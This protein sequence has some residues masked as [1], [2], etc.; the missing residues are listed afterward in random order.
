M[1]A[2][3]D[4]INSLRSLRAT[5]SMARV[6]KLLGPVAFLTGAQEAGQAASDLVGAKNKAQAREAG[7]RLTY[8]TV[9]AVGDGA[10]TV[11]TVAAASKVS[12]IT[13]AALAAGKFSGI[14]GGVAGV[15]EGG[16]Q[17]FSGAQE[18][19]AGKAGV[20]ALK[21]ASGGLM[22]AGVATANPFLLGAGG[23][24]YAGTIVWENREVI[25]QVASQGARALTDGVRGAGHLAGE[26]ANS[27]S[28][29]IQLMGDTAR[30]LLG[31]TRSTLS[32]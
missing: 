21:V 24:L 11:A 23:A 18:R 12:G 1:L 30:K 8:E 2:E 25:G 31:E 20:G 17:V 19:D 28:E 26:A 5:Q 14:A 29:R 10:E 32:L 15:A 22:L 16:I 9:S 6:G 3:A 4:K 27:A 7:G 13:K